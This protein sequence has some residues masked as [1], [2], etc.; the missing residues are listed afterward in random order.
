MYVYAPFIIC[1]PEYPI[2]PT[3]PSEMVGSMI[4]IGSEGN[5]VKS[6]DV[7]NT[8]R[9]MAKSPFASNINNLC[10]LCVWSVLGR[11]FDILPNIMI[12]MAFAH[13]PILTLSNI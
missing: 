9:E 3:A 11:F 10:A 12:E 8:I 6:K 2:H 4:C 1:T 13:N 7:I 5:N